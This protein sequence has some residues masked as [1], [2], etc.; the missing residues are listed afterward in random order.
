MAMAQVV[1]GLTLILV[2]ASVALPRLRALLKRRRQQVLAGLTEFF[3]AAFFAAA[4]RLSTPLIFTAVGG[5]FSERSAWSIS[6]W[7]A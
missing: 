1:Q 5:I 2:V 3:S 7:K 6:A 4:V